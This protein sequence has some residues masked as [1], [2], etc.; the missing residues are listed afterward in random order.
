[1]FSSLLA[2]TKLADA[3]YAINGPSTTEPGLATWAI[4]LIVAGG[5]LVVAIVIFVAVKLSRKNKK[6]YTDI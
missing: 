4:A 6:G 3:P 2:A 5:V 1:M